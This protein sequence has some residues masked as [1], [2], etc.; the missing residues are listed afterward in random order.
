MNELKSKLKV[1]RAFIT[2]KYK[3]IITTHPP[4]NN[5]EVNLRI[6]DSAI[7]MHGF[8]GTNDPKV[9]ISDSEKPFFT[10]KRNQSRD[11]QGLYGEGGNRKIP[12]R[13]IYCWYCDTITTQKDKDDRNTTWG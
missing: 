4:C 12:N 10:I 8:Y 6:V 5:K 13:R 9:K 1:L 7:T 3:K 11:Y 2:D